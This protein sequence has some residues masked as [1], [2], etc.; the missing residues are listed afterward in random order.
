MAKVKR[1]PALKVP[2]VTVRLGVGAT[3]V[4]MHRIF[5]TL[6][7]RE[8]KH[9]RT[10][11]VRECLTGSNIPSS[12]ERQRKDRGRREGCQERGYDARVVEVGF[13]GL[14]LQG[15]VVL[16]KGDG[17]EGSGKNEGEDEHD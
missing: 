10:G 12:L 3:S 13:N 5:S 16:A 17:R 4:Q 8:P 9:A 1:S 7:A 15:A 2:P 11:I 14:D 6:E